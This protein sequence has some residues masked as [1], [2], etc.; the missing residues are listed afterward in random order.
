MSLPT[1]DD[2]G[3]GPDAE[4]AWEHFGG[5]DLEDACAIFASCP[6]IYTDDVMWMGERAFKFYFPI[7]DRY[8]RAQS[9][10]QAEDDPP[11]M[12]AEFI[13]YCIQFHFDCHE[14]MSG[15]HA[16]II[17]LCDYVNSHLDHYVLELE[18]Q[19][20]AHT[21]WA[22]LRQQVVDDVNGIKRPRL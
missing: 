22:D 10:L 12:S 18:K 2:F 7:V 4:T 6:E 8:L 20:K 9:P 13:G 15:L 14:D 16:Q 21:R 11:M 1:R 5:K 3:G 17:D 19:E